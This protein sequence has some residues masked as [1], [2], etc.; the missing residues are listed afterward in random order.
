LIATNTIKKDD[1]AKHEHNWLTSVAIHGN[2]V[3]VGDCFGQLTKVMVD[4][5][6]TKMVWHHQKLWFNCTSL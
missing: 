4:K 1:M 2:V 6:T 3:V 5:C